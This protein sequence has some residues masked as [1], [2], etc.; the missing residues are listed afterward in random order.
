[1]VYHD[2]VLVLAI[3]HDIIKRGLQRIKII[4]A[5][6]KQAAATLKSVESK[7]ATYFC[8]LYIL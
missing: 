1:M 4:A 2:A 8:V 5:L 7:I 6:F 3:V